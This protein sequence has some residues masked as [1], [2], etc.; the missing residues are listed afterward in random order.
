MF[1]QHILPIL[2]QELAPK[3]NIEVSSRHSIDGVIE[4]PSIELYLSQEDWHT[5]KGFIDWNVGEDIR[6]T[7]DSLWYLLHGNSDSTTVWPEGG[8]FQ[9]G[10]SFIFPTTYDV[11]IRTSLLKL[12]LDHGGRI[13]I[14]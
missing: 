11:V 3:W 14:W 9:Y 4:D 13:E 12:T 6:Y 10:E 5:L 2:H 1:K 8:L 7:L